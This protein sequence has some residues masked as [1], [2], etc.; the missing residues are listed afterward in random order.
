MNDIWYYITTFLDLDVIIVLSHVNAILFTITRAY[1]N[2]VH[3]DLIY[4][5]LNKGYNN[6]TNFFINQQYNISSD[7][8]LLAIK[9]SHFE[10]LNRIDFNKLTI[11][12]LI[13]AIHSNNIKMVKFIKKR[14]KRTFCE[15]DVIYDILLVD[16][17]DIYKFLIGGTLYY[18]QL[19]R[20]VDYNCFNIIESYRFGTNRRDFEIAVVNHANHT[21]NRFMIQY[22]IENDYS[23][24][25]L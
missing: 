3:C 25:E 17:L 10:F 9:M 23:H 1:K 7:S 15:E 6:V 18:V 5:T 14:L 11:D 22:C 20:L 4:N 2:K 24:H 12:F 19:Q 13:L 16:N 21:N 8:I